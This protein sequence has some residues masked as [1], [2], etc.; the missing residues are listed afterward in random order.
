MMVIEVRTQKN[1]IGR[2]EIV[3]R[4][5]H[6]NGDSHYNVTWKGGH[7]EKLEFDVRHKRSDGPW[8]LAEKVCRIVKKEMDAFYSIP[9]E[10]FEDGLVRDSSIPKRWRKAFGKWLGV[11]TVSVIPRNPCPEG[12]V[13]VDG[14]KKT[15]TAFNASDVIGF[16]ESR[17]YGRVVMW[18]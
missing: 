12:C 11:A 6:T 9:K 10:A 7:G 14:D 8:R 16:L 2:A 15:E 1:V 3:H 17:R 5:V 18:D 4:F 13:D